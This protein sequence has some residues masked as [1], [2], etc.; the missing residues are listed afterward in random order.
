MKSV[1]NLKVGVRLGAALGLVI[2]LFIVVSVTAIVKTGS[3][4]GA[5]DRIIND[6]YIKVRLAFDVRDGVNDQIKFLR[7]MVIETAHPEKN[8]KRYGQLDDVTQQT[9]RT[10]EQIAKL[11][12]TEVGIKKI[13]AVKEAARQFEVAKNA[14]LDLVRAGNVDA[15]ADYAL[16]KMTPVQS[17]YL[18]IV[19]SFA[20][21]QS[22][23]LQAEGANAV[24]DGSTAIRI[25][26]IFSA[27]ATLAAIILGYFLTRSIV[28]PL[29]EA[30]QIAENVAAGDLRT[31]IRVDSA[32]E[33]GQ[34][35]QALKKMNE[36]LLRIVTEVRSGTELITTASGE[37]SLGNMD[38]SSRTEQQASSLEE[39]ASAMEQ[40]TSTVKQNAD[41]AR[42][43]NE[44]AALA[45]KVAVQSGTAVNQVVNTMETINA[46]SKKIVDIISVIDSIAF[47]TNIL[48]LNAAVEA[49][50][51]GE[52][53]RGFAVV[54]SE[55]RNLAQRSASAAKEIAQLIQDSVNKVDEGGKQVARA[56][57]TMEEVLASVKSVTEIMGEIS[58][59]S[60]EQSSGIGEINM[61]ITQMDQVTQQN[62]ALVNQS[63]AAAQSLQE[64]AEQLSQAISIFKVSHV[65][66]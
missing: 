47:Q 37:I 54:A 38:L 8:L 25:T 21:S 57:S 13:Q 10:I 45:S 18:N 20:D 23:Q 34:L 27:L 35:M 61:A 29:R 2:L 53:G 63:A 64:Q 36:N 26:L 46:S 51:A 66:G 3:I 58:I 32:D 11:Q 62:A 5:V 41:N 49:A 9:N 17:A 14:L 44:L 39:T 56:G 40:M 50:R 16:M 43:A 6:R 12:T 19:K 55:V 22:K 65:A 1:K 7:G 24:A 30:V 28:T 52:Q 48:A 60:H 33:T 31:V 4:N 59:A 15:A 42:Q